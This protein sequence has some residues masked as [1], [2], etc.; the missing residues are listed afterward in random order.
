MSK[1]KYPEFR[2]LLESYDIICLTEPKMDDL[3]SC[4]IDGFTY[5]VKNRTTCERKYGGI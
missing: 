2:E 1:M 3:D 4:D 5:C